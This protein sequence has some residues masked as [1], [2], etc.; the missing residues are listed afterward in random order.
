MIDMKEINKLI[1]LI[2]SKNWIAAH[3]L[4]DEEE[5]ADPGEQTVA[6]WRSVLLRKEGR[7]EEALEYLADNLYRFDCK[8]GALNN[9]AWI[10][11]IKGNDNGALNEIERAP[12]EA[13]IED[14]WA[15]VMEAKFF[16]LYLMARLGLAIPPEQ[17]AEIPDDYI[18]LLPTGERVP[19]NQLIAHAKGK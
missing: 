1:D 4:L 2:R 10:L 6:H 19:K 5:L 15:L 17:L 13:E 12:F 11:H 18:S 14:N 8:T 7:Y 16:R 9:R 3:A